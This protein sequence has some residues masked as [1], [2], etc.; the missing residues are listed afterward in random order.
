MLF[1]ETLWVASMESAKNMKYHVHLPVSMQG[2]RTHPS[3]K[4]QD[5][6]SRCDVQ[7]CYEMAMWLISFR[8]KDYRWCAKHTRKN[9]RESERWQGGPHDLDLGKSRTKSPEIT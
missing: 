4:R 7:G 8:G 1:P 5:T 3:L 2:P 6:S 9:M